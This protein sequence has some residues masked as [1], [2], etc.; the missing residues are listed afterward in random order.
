MLNSIKP[1]GFPLL[2]GF[3]RAARVFWN[4]TWTTRTGNPVEV[5][6]CS[7]S[8]Q[9]II[10]VVNSN[11]SLSINSKCVHPFYAESVKMAIIRLTRLLGF[12]F[13]SKKFSKVCFWLLFNRVRGRLLLSI[14]RGGSGVLRTSKIRT[15]AVIFS[16]RKMTLKPRQTQLNFVKQQQQKHRKA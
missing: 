2:F 13:F 1:A 14:G 10:S 3:L 11:S 9:Y 16:L 15:S 4:Q 5:A 7:R 8:C 12:G 6:N